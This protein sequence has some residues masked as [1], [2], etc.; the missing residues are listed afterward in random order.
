VTRSESADDGFLEIGSPTAPMHLDPGKAGPSS[1]EILFYLVSS[2][3][4]G[5]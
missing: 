3:N 1:E 2:E 4:S 5:S